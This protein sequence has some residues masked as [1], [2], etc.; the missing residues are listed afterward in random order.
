MYGLTDLVIRI[1][2][3]R[4]IWDSQRFLE[5]AFEYQEWSRKLPAIQFPWPIRITPP[6]NGAII[7][8]KV[9]YIGGEVSVYLDGYDQ[10]GAVGR[11]YWE[12]FP[13]AGDTLRFFLGEEEQLIAAI[14]RVID[15]VDK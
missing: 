10:L 9:P 3:Q 13:Y 7:R 15:G 1:K 4:K 2:R 12:I 5:E 8:F 14:Q 6:T 11:P